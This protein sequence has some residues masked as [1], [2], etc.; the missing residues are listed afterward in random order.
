MDDDP[1]VLADDNPSSPT[2]GTEHLTTQAEIDKINEM[3]GHL[4]LSS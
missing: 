3:I 4:G 2:Y 1:V